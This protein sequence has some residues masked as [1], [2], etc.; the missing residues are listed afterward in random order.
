MTMLKLNEPAAA[1][2]EAANVM[3]AEVD[4][5]E[6]RVVTVGTQVHVR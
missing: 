4:A 6:A 2:D 1:P 3:V 5:P